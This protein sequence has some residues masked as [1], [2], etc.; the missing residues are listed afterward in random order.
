M[1]KGW[2]CRDLGGL[3]TAEGAARRS[4]AQ[5]MVAREGRPRGGGTPPIGESSLRAS[6]LREP[7]YPDTP[8]WGAC[9]SHVCLLEKGG[10]DPIN[11]LMRGCPAC[12]V[13]PSEVGTGE[14]GDAAVLS[15]PWPPSSGPVRPY[16][17]KEVVEAPMAVWGQRRVL[18]ARG[19][20][21]AS[22]PPDQLVSATHG[23]GYWDQCLVEPTAV[24]D[25]PEPNGGKACIRH[26]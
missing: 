17:I 5:P 16:P 11:C 20:Y 9:P 14:K 21:A 25:V 13:S 1:G 24:K 2:G 8:D 12:P 18:W 22:S 19:A 3:W 26:A 6:T 7:D 10:R 23:L 4:D 15:G